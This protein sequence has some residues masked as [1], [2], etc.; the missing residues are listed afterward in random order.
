MPKCF[1]LSLLTLDSP[2][3]NGSDCQNY[4]KRHPLERM[5]IL[6]F[7]SAYSLGSDLSCGYSC[8]HHFKQCQ[9]PRPVKKK[10]T[11]PVCVEGIHRFQD[12]CSISG[13][14]VTEWSPA[15]R[16]PF[17]A[18]AVIFGHVCGGLINTIVVDY[19]LVTKGLVGA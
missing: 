19:P 2:M 8:A 18:T 12:T 10:I 9:T 14:L 17:R 5:S 13:A 11:R 15:C 6:C 3:E 4:E 16:R 1:E 7:Q